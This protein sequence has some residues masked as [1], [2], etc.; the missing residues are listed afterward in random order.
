[1]LTCG[2][3]CGII[4]TLEWI[5]SRLSSR[6]GVF[7]FQ[8]VLAIGSNDVFALDMVYLFGRFDHAGISSI[9]CDKFGIC[10]RTHSIS[11]NFWLAFQFVSVQWYDRSVGLR[12]K[13]GWSFNQWLEQQFPI[14][15]QKFIHSV[16][17]CPECTR[18]SVATHQ[19]RC[20]QSLPVPNCLTSYGSR[21]IHQTE[22][23]FSV[24]IAAPSDVNRSCWQQWLL[25]IA[26]STRAK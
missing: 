20:D 1:M 8:C 2:I 17:F 3:M 24:S 9:N 25:M 15:L 23:L 26:D 22:L 19:F 16:S 5:H 10:A 7:V 6:L 12:P 21:N 11:S 13:I 14:V 18:T 4:N